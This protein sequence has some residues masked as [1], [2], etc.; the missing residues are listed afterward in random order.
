[1]TRR[2]LTQLLLDGIGIAVGIGEDLGDELIEALIVDAA[3]EAVHRT[4]GG[5]EGLEGIGSPRH[6]DRAPREFVVEGT[7]LRPSSKPSGT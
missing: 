3:H 7:A 6:L 4:I 1:M 5:T 2:E